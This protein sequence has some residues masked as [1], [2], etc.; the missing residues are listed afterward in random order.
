M[1]NSLQKNVFVNPQSYKYSIHKNSLE[2]TN[3]ILITLAPGLR[4]KE[5]NI[6]RQQSNE[7][8]QEKEKGRGEKEKYYLYHSV[9]K[10]EHNETEESNDFNFS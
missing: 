7:R 3:V 6:Q 8:F 10:V 2:F 9:I 5:T 1:K 4:K